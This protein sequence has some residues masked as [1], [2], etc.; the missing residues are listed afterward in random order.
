MRKLL[1]SL[2]ASAILYG[3]SFGQEISRS[4]LASSGG[5]LTN[6]S[7]QLSFTLGEPLSGTCA[8]STC[9]LNLGFQQ[10]YIEVSSLNPEKKMFEL[11]VYPNPVNSFLNIEIDE[12]TNGQY[13]AVLLDL[14]GKKV[15]E[16]NLYKGILT[17][18]VEELPQSIYILQIYNNTGNMQTFKLI[19]N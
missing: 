13:N 17:L 7:A 10:V 16:Y 8:V 1:L 12:P 2:L 3:L 9:Y 14:N 18:D 4:V 11:S 19:K 5:D 15:G 6:S